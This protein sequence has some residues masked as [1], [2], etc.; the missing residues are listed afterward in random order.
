MAKYIQS[1][2][3]KNFQQ[4]KFYVTKLSFRIE[5]EVEFSRQTKVKVHHTKPD[6]EEIL[7]L[8]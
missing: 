7:K 1:V 8:L 5:G 3:R 6:L 4:R 2:E